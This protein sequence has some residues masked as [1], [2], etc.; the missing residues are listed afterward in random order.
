MDHKVME[1][2]GYGL[3]IVTG[4]DE[5]QDN[6][7]ITNCVMQV[8]SGEV[9]MVMALNKRNLTHD[10]IMKNKVFNV[11]VLSREASFAQI[12]RF[13]FLSGRE[14]DKFKDYPMAKRADNEVLYVT[15]GTNA[16]LSGLVYNTMDMGSHT[17]FLAEVT[18]AQMIKEA[19]S[20]SYAYYRGHIKP[21]STVL[22]GKK[23]EAHCH[24]KSEGAY[25]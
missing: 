15:E 14:C 2:L 16:Y 11:S 23:G 21:Q 18:D 7:C 24:K 5:N 12:Q 25:S 1:K 19:P 20:A 9:R 17:L 22:P 8:T 10:M 13:G 3:Y 6:G 4:K